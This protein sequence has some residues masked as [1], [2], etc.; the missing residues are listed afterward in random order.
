MNDE[1]DL[2]SAYA[3]GSL[4]ETKRLYATW[5][6]TYDADFGAAQGYLSP[7]EVVAAVAALGAEGPC[8]DVGAGTGLVGE[9]LAAIGVTDVD[10]LDISEQML[11]VAKHKG[12][13]RD[14]IVAD[15]TRTLPVCGYNLIVSAGT[16]TFGHVGPE[17]LPPLLDAGRQ[18][19]R[20]VLTV[21]AEHFATAGFAKAFDAMGSN[22]TGFE[23]RDFRIY[24]DK[25][26]LSH[27]YDIAK[28]VQFEKA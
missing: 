25:A 23:T 10:A 1:P 18:G 27:R 20:F 22:I 2:K 26:D 11:E 7:R 5:A 3:L 17:G 9:G 8:L 28:L 21:N 6:A 4:D 19:C 15:V 14:L 12:V 13:Y 16:F 24:S